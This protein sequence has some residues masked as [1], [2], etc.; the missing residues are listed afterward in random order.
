[1]PYAVKHDP[2]LDI[3]E[4]TLTGS[5]TSTT[6]REATTK[7]VSLQKQTRT[8]RFLVDPNG[9]ELGASISDIY[10]LPA[11]QYPKENL[12]PRS[13]IAV[14]LPASARAQEIARFYETV[15]RNRGWN[16]RI[17]PDRQSAIEWLRSAGSS[18]QSNAR[19]G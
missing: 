14:I 10:D 9:A 17:F 19:N 16:A 15:C 5:L 13:Q 11:E 3:I 8:T 7:G 12:D 6:L 1:M 18:D 4:L 2:L